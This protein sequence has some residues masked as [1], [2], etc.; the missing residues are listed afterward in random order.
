MLIQRIGKFYASFLN[1]RPQH[2]KIAM[3]FGVV[4]VSGALFLAFHPHASAEIGKDVIAP[5]VGYLLTIVF[6]LLGKLLTAI[7]DMLIK[8]AQYNNIIDQPTVQSTWVLMKDFVNMFFVFGLLLIAFSTILHLQDYE[9]KRRL[10]KFIF[11]AVLVNFS[12]TICGLFIDIGQIIMLT[13]VNAFKGD[14]LNNLTSMTGLLEYGNLQLGEGTVTAQE[15]IGGYILAIV[16]MVVAIAAIGAMLVMLIVRILFLW[17][18]VILSPFAFVLPAIPRAEKYAGQ[19]WDMFSKQVMTGPLLAFFIWLALTVVGNNTDL[20]TSIVGPN[21]VEIVQTKAGGSGFFINFLIA[22]GMLFAGLMLTSQMGGAAGKIA[23]SVSGKLQS[24]GTGIATGR[25]GPTPMRW[26]RERWGS[27]RGQRESIRK[28]QVSRFG[29]GMSAVQDRQITGRLS[30]MTGGVTGALTGG[31]WRAGELRGKRA[32]ER[33]NSYDEKKTAT[34]IRSY[35]KSANLDQLDETQL[36]QRIQ[37]PNISHKDYAASVDMLNNK[38][39]L[40]R[41]TGDVDILNRGR[42]FFNRAP[43]L[44]QKFD[45]TAKKVD[46][47]M[48]FESDIY[49]NADGTPNVDRFNSDVYQGKV[50]PSAIKKG[51]VDV[52]DKHLGG[53][54]AYFT[55]LARGVHDPKEMAR[56][57]GGLEQDLKGSEMGKVDTS[58]LSDEMKV[59]FG[60]ATNHWERVFEPKESKGRNID[61]DSP[62]A[63]QEAQEEA[64]IAALSEDQAH[65]FFSKKEN[66]SVFT[67]ADGDS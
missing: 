8:V 34:D 49:R 35:Q 17:I 9:A 65:T 54:G 46:A 19:W 4:F 20:G 1:L 30:A 47:Q 26:A 5:A 58:A 7:I 25:I 27:Y 57:F 10:P 23:G 64:H 18:L 52:M 3:I 59:A 40:G 38:G 44:R 66:R 13:F 14:A 56:I 42:Q 43:E 22:I 2:R 48:A 63:V 6:S 32:Q 51:M 37:Q 39:A 55:N 61:L 67:K 62:E 41:Q 15:V 60:S 11:Y 21:G 36:R 45:D 28:E 24:M 33:A 16:F 29:Q 53:Q 50:S 31:R 12:I